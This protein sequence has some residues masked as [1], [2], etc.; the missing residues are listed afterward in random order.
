MGEIANKNDNIRT[1]LQEAWIELL[2]LADV[3][4]TDN[5]YHLGGHQLPQSA[6]LSG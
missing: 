2:Q 6:C 1:A 3:S 5:F 4:E